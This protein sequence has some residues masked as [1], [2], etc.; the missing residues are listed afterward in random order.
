MRL[1][2]IFRQIQMKSTLLLIILTLKVVKNDS[3]FWK[4]LHGSVFLSFCSSRKVELSPQALSE[5]ED[6]RV[7]LK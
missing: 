2:F 6:A 3:K 4:Q 7:G 5:Q 1:S